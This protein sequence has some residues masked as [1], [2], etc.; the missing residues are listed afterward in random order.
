[1]LVAAGSRGR[2]RIVCYVNGVG[3]QDELV[4]DGQSL[5]FDP[6][7]EAR[8]PRAAVRGAAAGRGLDAAASPREA[9]GPRRPA[10]LAWP[11]EIDH[12]DGES[13]PPDAG[14]RAP[15]SV[16]AGEPRSHGGSCASSTRCALSVEAEVY[17]ALCLGV[18]DY[19]RKNG[20]QQVVMGISGGIDSAL[21]ACIA[22]DALGRDRVNAVSMP[23]RY[24]SAGTRSDARET[25]ERLGVNFY[26]IPIESIYRSYLESPRARTSG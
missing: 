17:A 20:F 7:G 24:S 9:V 19:V 6:G 15:R 16:I 18:S 10:R 23:S 14:R 13:R 1:M 4:F 21:T 3:G 11:V 12:H 2:R 22:A 8:G 25:A 26:E 5:V